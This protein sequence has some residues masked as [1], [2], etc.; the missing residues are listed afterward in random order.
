MEAHSLVIPKRPRTEIAAGFNLEIKRQ[1]ALLDSIEEVEEGRKRLDAWRAY[2]TKRE[3][4][5]EIAAAARW[6]EIRIGELLGPAEAVAGPGRGKK[7]LLMSNALSAGQRQDHHKFR[8]LAEN[9]PLVSRLIADG[10]VSR[11]HILQAIKENKAASKP[12]ALS[13][14]HTVSGLSELEGKQFGCVYADP[15]WQYGNQSTRA[16][17]DNHYGTLTVD[18]LCSWPVESVVA[19]DA[20]LHL[21]TTNAFLPDAFRVIEDWGFEYRSCFV[22]VKPQMGIGNYW[23]VSHEF[24]LLGIRGDAKRFNSHSLKSWGEF[25]RTRHSSKPSAVR[26]L[27]ESASSGPYLELFGRSEVSGW[28]VLGNQVEAKL[29]S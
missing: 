4:K 12:K 20:H 18:Q 2:V 21:W 1:V 23:R 15:P 7:A 11:N 22:W 28:T 9:K 26:E 6:C 25:D 8:L 5:N 17:T 16:A 19:D 10:Q 29:F 3:Q 13:A 14:A 27:I 24:L